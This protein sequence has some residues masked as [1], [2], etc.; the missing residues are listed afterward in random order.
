MVEDG[1]DATLELVQKIR[2]HEER[3]N[4]EVTNHK[5]L[6]DASRKE[7]SIANETKKRE[8]N[9][10]LELEEAADDPAPVNPFTV[11]NGGRQLPTSRNED[12]TKELAITNP[13]F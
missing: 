4:Q 10:A 5:V 11:T 9:N 7:R 1:N 3:R 2:D 6:Q 12:P 8:V 13:Q